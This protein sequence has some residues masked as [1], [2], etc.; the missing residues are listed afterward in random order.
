MIQKIHLLFK[1][2]GLSSVSQQPGIT[3][4]VSLLMPEYI[5]WEKNGRQTCYQHIPER[6]THACMCLML[7]KKAAAASDGNPNPTCQPPPPHPVLGQS[8]CPLPQP[9]SGTLSQAGLNCQ[10]EWQWYTDRLP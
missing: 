2:T 9:S 10:A 8:S 6:D 1:G 7:G 5:S 3:D 4:P